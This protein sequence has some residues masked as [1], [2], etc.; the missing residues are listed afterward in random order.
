MNSNLQLI[1]VDA[2]MKPA[3]EY[4]AIGNDP[5]L[6]DQLIAKS[7]QPAILEYTPK[8]AK[9]RFANRHALQQWLA[10]GRHVHWLLGPGRDLAGIIWYGKADFP[11]NI[12]LPEEVPTE[13][14]AIRLYE[15]Y[16]GHGLARPFMALSLRVYAEQLQKQGESLPGIWLQ[17]NVDNHAALAVYAK[18]GYTEI[19]HDEER[20]TM[21]L[22]AQHILQITGL[23]Q[24]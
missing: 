17:T 7:R 11:L 4:L 20:V 23:A 15:G 5:E 3:V 12:P 16:V 6:A 13:T 8:D 1:E 19:Y 14:F 18:F 9:E 10:K 21:V 24:S 2:N 22:S